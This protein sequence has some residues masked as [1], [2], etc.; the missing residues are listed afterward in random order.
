LTSSA[1]SGCDD[2]AGSGGGEDIRLIGD[3]TVKSTVIL[4]FIAVNL[5]RI[6]VVDAEVDV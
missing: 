2:T 5:S 3:D 6:D 4:L 1:T